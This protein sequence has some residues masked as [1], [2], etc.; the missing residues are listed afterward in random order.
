MP[1][2][3][4]LS[5]AVGEKLK[6]LARKWFGAFGIDIVRL[7]RGGSAP[8][9]GSFPPHAEYSIIGRPENYYIHANYKQR[10]EAVY[11]RDTGNTDQWQLEIYKFAREVLDQKGLRHVCDIGCGSAY[12]LMKYF[13]DCHTVGLDVAKT[14][15]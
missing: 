15:K 1:L 12:K 3:P 11:Y 6:P 14:C 8:I 2:V 9:V 7:H 5:V 4:D 13:A 10:N